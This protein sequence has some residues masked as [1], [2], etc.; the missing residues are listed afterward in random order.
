MPPSAHLALFDGFDPPDA[1]TPF[2]VLAAGRRV[3]S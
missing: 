2:V 1:L 3:S